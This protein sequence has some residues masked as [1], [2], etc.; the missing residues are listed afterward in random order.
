MIRRNVVLLPMAVL[1]LG[2]FAVTF[3][4]IAYATRIKDKD[5]TKSKGVCR[6]PSSPADALGIIAALFILA[7]QIVLRLAI[8]CFCCCGQRFSKR[9][10]YITSL[11]FYICS[12]LTF[13]IAFVGLIYT[14]MLNNSHYLAKTYPGINGDDCNVG[15]EKYYIGD[16]LW[17]I[18]ST[19]LGLTS[20]AFWVKG[21][22]KTSDN[23]Q[24]SS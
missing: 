2:V 12:W 18:I 17:C 16:A 14:A 20:Y 8:K 13:V 10:S 5:V 24:G 23:S 15:N 19:V 7:Q 4:F 21:T 6:Y 1:L 3:S 9:C 22:A 11:F